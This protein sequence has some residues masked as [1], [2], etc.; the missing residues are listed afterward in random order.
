MIF[1]SQGMLRPALDVGASSYKP[2]KTGCWPV[3]PQ[4]TTI[5]LRASLFPYGWIVRL[6]YSGPA[7]TMQ[8]R[9]GAAVRDARLQAGNGV[10][11][12]PVVGSGSTVVVRRLSPGPPVCISSLTVGLI[13]ATRPSAHQAR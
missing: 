2:G 11:Y 3:L 7:A 12:V 8:L 1:N 5:P 6:R 9:F 10:L 13:Y 4:A